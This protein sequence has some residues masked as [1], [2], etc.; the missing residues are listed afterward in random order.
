VTP[1]VGT[2]FDVTD[3]LSVFLGYGE[4]FRAVTALFGE[5]AKPEESSQIEG[6]IKFDFYDIGGRLFCFFLP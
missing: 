5:T 1:R 6:G 3:K 2:V 4:G